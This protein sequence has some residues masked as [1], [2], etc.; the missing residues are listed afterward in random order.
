MLLEIA[1]DDP[2]FTSMSRKSGSL[3]DQAAALVRAQARRDR[4]GAAAAHV[5]VGGYRIENTARVVRN[6]LAFCD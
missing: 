6:I 3:R 2:G 1:T 5:I 4:G